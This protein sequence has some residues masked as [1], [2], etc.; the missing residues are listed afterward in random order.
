MDRDSG[1]TEESL[2][3]VL[4]R[5]GGGNK[6]LEGFLGFERIVKSRPFEEELRSDGVT[7]HVK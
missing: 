7:K 3:E 1:M 6:D 4:R 2:E 5:V